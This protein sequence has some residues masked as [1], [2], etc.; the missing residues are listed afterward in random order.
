M[1]EHVG[2]DLNS[3]N[4]R[5]LCNLLKLGE[6]DSITYYECTQ[7][8]KNKS[9]LKKTINYLRKIWLIAD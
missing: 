2:V 1:K 3:L 4:K 7:E 8:L 9:L 5:Q 6:I